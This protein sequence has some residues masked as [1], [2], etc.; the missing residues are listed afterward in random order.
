MTNEQRCKSCGAAIYWLKHESTKRPAPVDALPDPKGK[1]NIA[2]DFE[3]GT[4]RIAMFD[5]SLH[6]NHFV[7]CPQAGEWAKKKK[8]G[9]V[10]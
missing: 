3:A 1:G 5:K 9:E 7:T 2:P 8:A 4:Y 10:V 6:L